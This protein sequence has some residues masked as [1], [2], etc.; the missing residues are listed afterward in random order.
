MI[1]EATGNAAVATPWWMATTHTVEPI[2][3]A[4]DGSG[5]QRWLR[6]ATDVWEKKGDL[7]HVFEACSPLMKPQT[8]TPCE[9]VSPNRRLLLRPDAVT[10][11]FSW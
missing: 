8:N 9:L 11:A 10:A 3:D 7:T 4:T 1:V 5:K 2:A 6:I